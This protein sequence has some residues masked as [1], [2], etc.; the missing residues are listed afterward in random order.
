MKGHLRQRGKEGIWYAVFE[1]RDE[2]GQRRRRWMCLKTTSKRKA[3][4]ELTRLLSEKA[5][6]ILPPPGRVTVSELLTAYIESRR[7]AGRAPSTLLNYAHLAE[8][9][10]PRIG[11]VPLAD[12]KPGHLEA[13]YR[14]EIASTDRRRTSAKHPNKREHLK[15][16]G[17]EKKLSATTVRHEHDLLRTALK[18]A[19]RQGL[20]VRSPAD[21]ATPPRR[22][23]TEQRVLTP[24]Q[25]ATLLASL[26]GHRLWAM[27]YLAVTTG[28]RQGELA[29]LRWSDVDLAGTRLG[30]RV[31]RQYL[32]HQGIVERETKE[33]RGTRPIELTDEEVAVL[34]RHRALMAEE[35]RRMGGSLHPPDLVFPSEVGTPLSP[36]NIQRFFH[37]ALQRADLPDIRFHD[38]RHTAGMLLMREDGRVV[39]AQQRLGHA[40]PST[41]LNTYGHAL[42]G[43]QR[44]A[45]GKV[46][47]AIHR[48][49]T[50]S[51]EWDAER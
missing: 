30:V 20:L 40:K 26:E 10:K 2:S 11:H 37:D 38:L 34:R 46:V 42:P 22:V 12:L 41:T 51:D 18:Y 28:M 39:V 17:G 9:I 50:R 32:P 48:A 8:R 19:V 16:P 3:E 44:V 33:H 25:V 14:A 24:Q 27:I 21:A 31:Q 29:G 6:G 4:D 15:H 36:R 49:R 13:L 5:E 45:A 35:R 23:H 43:D 47:A 7:I 1:D